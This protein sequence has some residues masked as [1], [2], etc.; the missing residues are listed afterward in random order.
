MNNNAFVRFV[1]RL[2]VA[3]LVLLPL[4]SQAELIGTGQVQSAATTASLRAGV[5][6]QLVAFGLAREAAKARVAALSDSEIAQ[7][8]A[9]GLQD[10]PA[11]GNSLLAIVVVALLIYFLIAK[12]SMEGKPA[13]KK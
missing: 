9:A 3:S 8:Q 12:P 5:E 10:A 4:S 6:D 2:L 7:L 11:G 1:C 13:A